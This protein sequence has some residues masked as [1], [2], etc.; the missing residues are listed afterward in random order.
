MKTTLNEILKH[1][2]CGTDSGGES[3]FSLGLKNAGKLK[4]DDEPI[5]L[6]DIL[7]SN[8]IRDAI[9]VLRCFDYLDYCLFIADIL[10]SNLDVFDDKTKIMLKEIAKNIRGYKLGKISKVEFQELEN[11]DDINDFVFAY[12]FAKT[13]TKIW[14]SY[15]SIF[16]KHFGE[17]K[18]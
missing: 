18:S 4:A 10:E 15:E 2:P 14:E 7:K 11:I 6:I 13:K 16:I 9:W 1:D 17:S 3:G 5:D 8:G 12:D